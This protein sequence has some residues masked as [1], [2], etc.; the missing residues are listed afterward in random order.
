M[1]IHNV[2]QLG[3]GREFAK[4]ESVQRDRAQHPK[5]VVIAISIGVNKNG[6]AS[7]SV[8]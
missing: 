8:D 3:D 5:S 4:P 2:S 1:L 6:L 7:S